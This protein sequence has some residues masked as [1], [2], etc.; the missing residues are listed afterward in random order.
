MEMINRFRRQF[1]YNAWANR[2]VLASLTA[3]RPATPGASPPVVPARTLEVMA[4][5]IGAELAWLRR[6]GPAVEYMPVWPDLTVTECQFW[7]EHLSCTWERYIGGLTAQE[8]AREITYTNFK[9]ERWTNNVEDI[10]THVFTHACYHRGQIASLLGRAGLPAPYTDFIEC[11]R[12]GCI[13][14]EWA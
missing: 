10:L 12:R 13:E 6:L 14:A 9:G 5:L 7:L 8:L 11:V 2:E 1:A 3:E 4:H